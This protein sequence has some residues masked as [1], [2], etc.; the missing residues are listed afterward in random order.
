MRKKKKEA[1]NQGLA[2]DFNLVIPIPNFGVLFDTLFS[3]NSHILLSTK[4][5][6]FL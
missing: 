1:K 4:S 3:L 6:I 5:Y 2:L